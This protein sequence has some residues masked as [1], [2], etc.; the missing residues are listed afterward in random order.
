MEGL[1]DGRG[2]RRKN[3]GLEAC[4]PVL[5]E[6]PCFRIP[7][8][9]DRGLPHKPIT[10]LRSSVHA[11]LEAGRWFSQSHRRTPLWKLVVPTPY[12]WSPGPRLGLSAYFHRPFLPVDLYLRLSPTQ[13]LVLVSAR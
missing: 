4:Q 11:E 13:E 9:S 2:G 10:A 3:L 6:P 12:S 8:E 5:P 1:G 7:Y